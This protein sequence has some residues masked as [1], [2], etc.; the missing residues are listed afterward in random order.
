MILDSV[1][2][3]CNGYIVRMATYALKNVYAIT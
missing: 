2:Q 3:N 1:F